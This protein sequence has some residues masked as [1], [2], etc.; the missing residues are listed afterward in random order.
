MLPAAWADFALRPPRAHGEPLFGARIRARPEH[1]QVDEELGFAA[2]GDGPH[3]LLKVRKCGANTEWVARELARHAGVRPHDVGFAGLKD[4]HA[5]ATQWFTAPAGRRSQD[6]WR[7]LR[8][9]GYEV[10]EAHAHNRK[11]RRGALAGNRFSILLTDVPPATDRA[12]AARRIERLAAD[13]VPNYFGPQRFGR[14]LGNLRRAAAAARGPEAGAIGVRWRGRDERSFALSAAR[15]LIFNTVLAARV[16]D[17]SW[18]HL[19]PGDLANFDDGGTIFPVSA[20]DNSLAE[21]IASGELHATGPLWG[22]TELAPQGH[23]AA[24]EQQAAATCDPLGSWLLAE[25]LQAERRALRLRVRDLRHEWLPAEGGLR[26]SFALT[27]GAYATMVL[28]ELADID[29]AA[30]AGDQAVRST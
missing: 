30:Q 25:G 2:A 11:L 6:E 16:A 28:N 20:M 21:R 18:R 29:D 5:V 3:W 27:S 23:V 9:E 13:G 15:S 10:L 12:A 4:R 24:L 7:A 26:L 14:E 22:L 19:Q 17:G 8:G 1:F